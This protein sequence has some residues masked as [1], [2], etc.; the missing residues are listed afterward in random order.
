M[1]SV[2]NTGIFGTKGRK[3]E[4]SSVLLSGIWL[5]HLKFLSQTITVLYYAQVH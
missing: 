1:L 4:R 2:R 3:P 5:L